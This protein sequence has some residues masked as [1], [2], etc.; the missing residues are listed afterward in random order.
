MAG[1]EGCTITDIAD[2]AT[3]DDPSMENRLRYTPPAGKW[4][5][6]FTTL[7]VKVADQY[8]S[9]DPVTITVSIYHIDIP[10]VVVP[11]S[12]TTQGNTYDLSAAVINVIQ[13]YP[14]VVAWNLTDVDS[15]PSNLTSLIL[16]L[17]YRGVVYLCVETA[18]GYVAGDAVTKLGV[19]VA[20]SSDGLFRVIYVPPAGESGSNFASISVAGALFFF[21]IISRN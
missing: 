2:G 19:V 20:P 11:I 7:V 16:Y 1:D 8:G 18:D 15:P 17:P 4:G 21:I 5:T 14:A 12:Y 6:N 10:P 9:S 13:D 3:L